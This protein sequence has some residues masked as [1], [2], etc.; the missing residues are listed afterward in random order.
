MVIAMMVVIATMPI[1]R[2]AESEGHNRGSDHHRRRRNHH[3]RG[4]ANRRCRGYVYRRGLDIYRSRSYNDS[5]RR[6]N[7]MPK[8]NRT[9]ACEAV[10]IPSKTAESNNS[11]FIYKYRRNLAPRIEPAAKFFSIFL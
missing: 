11:L 10:V 2:M 4:R 1:A 5:R 7:G 3:G 8:L 6:R 9:P